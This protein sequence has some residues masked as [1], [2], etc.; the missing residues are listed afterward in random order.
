MQVITPC[1]DSSRLG[2][3]AQ[4]LQL[5]RHSAKEYSLKAYAW[6][7]VEGP[8]RLSKPVILDTLT[9]P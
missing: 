8:L 4:D 9:Q 1:I 7:P 5:T 3:G 2:A 6:A